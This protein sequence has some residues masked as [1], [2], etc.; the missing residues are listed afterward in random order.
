[1]R[2]LFSDNSK[3]LTDWYLLEPKLPH[4]F[5]DLSLQQGSIKLLLSS[6]KIYFTSPCALWLPLKMLAIFKL[7]NGKERVGSEIKK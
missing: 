4:I 6:G 5:S 7:C 3:D 1:M 2:E